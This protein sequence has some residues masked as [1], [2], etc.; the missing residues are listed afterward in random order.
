MIPNSGI[1][2]RKSEIA[3]T[4]RWSISNLKI[5]LGFLGCTF[6]RKKVP[7]KQVRHRK[8]SRKIVAPFAAHPNSVRPPEKRT[9]GRT[10]NRWMCG[11]SLSLDFSG[12]F[13][14]S[15]CQGIPGRWRRG[16]LDAE[17]SKFGN[18]KSEMSRPPRC[19]PLF[20]AINAQRTIVDRPLSCGKGGIR[21][22]G[23]L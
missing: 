9:V 1:G 21:T 17:K 16:C 14:R 13:P 19:P 8:S 4:P 23:T 22:H 18:R 2:N 10:S 5:L 20:R 7:K 11:R 6:F 12:R 15:H 3:Q